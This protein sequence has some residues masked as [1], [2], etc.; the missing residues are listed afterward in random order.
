MQLKPALRS[1]MNIQKKKLLAV[2]S[3]GGH[4]IQLLRLK[5]AFDANEVIFVSTSKGNAKEVDGYKFY[6]IINATRKSFWNFFIMFFQLFTIMRQVH[7]DIIITT[8]SAPGL[9]ALVVGRIF[10]TRNVWIDSIANVNELSSS[11]K[12]ARYFADLYLTQWK[13]LTKPG[14]PHF[15]GSVI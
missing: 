10:R 3:S 1:K 9:M 8:G 11:G 4:W 14:G 7:P 2:A 13:K 12:K 5:P 6:N 15:K